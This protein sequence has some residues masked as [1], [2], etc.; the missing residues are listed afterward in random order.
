MTWEQ[1]RAW[2][3]LQY[4]HCAHDTA[5]LGVRA[6]EELS[7]Q[8][9]RAGERWAARARK[10]WARRARGARRCDTAGWAAWAWSVR[11]SWAR[12]GHCA[13]DPILTQF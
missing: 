11:A 13:P 12:L 9:G 5:K 1:G 8:V 6:R 2:A 10:R 3:V 7:A 4:S